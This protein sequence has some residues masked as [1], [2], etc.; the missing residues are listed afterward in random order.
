ME[1]ANGTVENIDTTPA[2]N[3]A[4][5][6]ENENEYQLTLDEL[7][8]ADFADDP[9]MSTTHKGLKPYNQILESLPEDARKLVANLRAMSTQKTQEVAEGRR[10]LEIERANLVRDREALLSGNFKQRIDAL[11][12]DQTAFDPWSEEGIQQKIQQEA[13]KMF[14]QMLNPLQQEL[15]QTKR[16]SQLEAFKSAN[17][18][19]MNYKDDIAKMLVAR[20]DLK[21][22]DAY[23]IVKGQKAAAQAGQDRDAAKNRVSAVSKTSTGQ[24]I[25]GTV[26]PKFKDSWEAYQYFKQNPQASEAINRNG[27]KIR[28]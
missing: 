27:N 16:S 1:N 2:E 9:V 23:Y 17:P 4:A 24:N 22:E 10:Q 6:V 20:E 3:E 13:A 8:K 18:D 7:M 12:S 14:Q 21:L 28:R 11:A 25:N 15:E 19:L 5:V 26:V